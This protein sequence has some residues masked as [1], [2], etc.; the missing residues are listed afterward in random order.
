MRTTIMLTILSVLLLCTTTQGAEKTNITI[1]LTV[2][3]A[4]WTIAI[5]EVYKVKN[6]IWV[7]SRI[8]RDPDVMGAQV[9][10]KVRDAVEIAPDL[11][12]K[13]FII[14]KAWGWKN[15]EPY[16]FIKDLKE[17]EKEL[18]AGS[19]LYKRSEKETQKK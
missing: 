12:V 9:I 2:P 4:A 10:S 14:G 6:E 7:I 1:E 3:D 17:I 8:S 15:E 11:P 16:S 19:R 5:E 13:H 18:K